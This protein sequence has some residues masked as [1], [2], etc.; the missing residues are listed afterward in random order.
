[1]GKERQAERQIV[2][3]GGGGFSMESG[4]PLL[5]D[6]VCSLTGNIR[7]RV[8]FLPTASGDADHYI[9]RFYNAFRDTSYPS[10][11]SL[12]PSRAWGRQHP[13][14][15]LLDQDMIYVGGGSVV[16]M[17][18][19]WR[20][21]GIDEILREA[22]QRGVVLCGL[23]AGSLCWFDHALT[24]YQN[25]VRLVPGLGL[26]PFGN[27]VHFKPGSEQHREF[28]NRLDEVSY[29]GYAATDGAALHFVGTELAQVVASR[30]EARAYRIDRRGDR[31]R[32]TQ[33]ATRHL[34]SA[35][36]VP[37]V[38]PTSYAWSMPSSLSV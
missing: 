32:T 5:D 14:D 26:L 7:P 27:S 3:F 11:I 31:A 6:F 20:A 19:V 9:V 16:N 33:I 21:H 23:S 12:V 15:H 17:L 22:W 34:G 35:D 24:G 1:M 10:H 30:P 38:D 28:E 8:C 2:A 13:R 25:E 36:H 4:N 18:A 29:A 37:L